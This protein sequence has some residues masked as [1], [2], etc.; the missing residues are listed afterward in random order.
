MESWQGCLSG[1]ENGRLTNQ[2]RAAHAPPLS[3]SHVNVHCSPVHLS[4]LSCLACNKLPQTWKSVWLGAFS[5]K[6]LC[7]HA[8]ASAGMCITVAPAAGVRAPAN[9]WLT[10][11]LP[12]GSLVS[13]PPLKVNSPAQLVVGLFPGLRVL[14]TRGWQ[15][16]VVRA[17]WQ[18][19]GATGLSNPKHKRVTAVPAANAGQPSTHTSSPQKPPPHSLV[20]LS[21]PSTVAAPGWWEG[22]ER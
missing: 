10:T 12:W 22:D 5:C 1:Q 18:A 16:T 4:L 15:R 19:G 6:K 13:L 8:A 9:P 21:S 14:Q 2:A 17:W 20:T 11:P 3:S 7:K